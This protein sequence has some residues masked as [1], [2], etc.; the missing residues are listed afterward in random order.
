[1]KLKRILAFLLAL[2]VCVSILAG[3]GNSSSDNKTTAADKQTNASGGEGSTENTENSKAVTFPLSEKVSISMYAPQP[4]SD[5]PLTTNVAWQKMEELTNVHFELTSFD[6]AEMKERLNLLLNG[7]DYLEVIYSPNVIDVAKYGE[8]G[9]LIPL[10]D[11]IREYMPNLTRILDERGGWVDLTES[12]GHIYSLPQITMPLNKDSSSPVWINKEWLENLG[13]EEPTNRDELYAVLKAF[14]EKDPNGNGKQDEIPWITYSG[15]ENSLLATMCEVMYYNGNWAVM[16]EK[17][18]YLPTTDYFKDY[19]KFLTKLYEEELVNADMFT[20][21]V[22]QVK[23]VAQSGDVVGMFRSSTAGFAETNAEDRWN[24]VTL[25]PFNTEKYFLRSGINAGALSITD[26]C[27]NPELVCQWADYLYSEEGSL[28]Y[29]L[30]VE[31][32]SYKKSDDGTSYSKI[33]DFGN[34]TAQAALVGVCRAPGIYPEIYYTGLDPNDEANSANLHTNKE[35]YSKDYGV[36]SKGVFA[37]K[38]IYTEEEDKAI[39]S[40][41]VDVRGYVS[42]YTAEVVTGIRDIDSTWNDF[43]KTMKEMGVETWIEAT[44][45]AYARGLEAM[46]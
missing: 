35:K 21:S 44:R 2:V 42:S 24:W 25:K 20:A 28:L 16:D 17:V 34:R 1:M 37:P 36:F 5:Y 32:V 6:S 15:E 45:A 31:D 23:A 27:A 14:K 29:A 12:D 11:L 13:M 33:G 10:E 30:G 7:G 41:K 9:V 4:T 39:E 19:L 3:C 18:E 46:K 26:K 40:I 22:E 8:D 43:Q 38:F